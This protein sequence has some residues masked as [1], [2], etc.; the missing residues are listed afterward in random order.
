KVSLEIKILGPG[1]APAG[2]GFTACQLD[3]LFEEPH[4][5][6]MRQAVDEWH[7]THTV[8][9]PPTFANHGPAEAGHYVRITRSLPR[10][11]VNALV[12]RFADV[13]RE[14]PARQLVHAPGEGMTVTASDVWD[15]H[16]RYADT[17]AGLDLERDQLIISAIGNH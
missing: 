8:Y 15:R 14:N 16:R 17:L 5:R 10:I 2:G 11:M 1:H 13:H 3:D 12:K 7:S 6:L 9:F 4:R